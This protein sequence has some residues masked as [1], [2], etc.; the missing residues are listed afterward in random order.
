LALC[1]VGG[2]WASAGGAV[3][4]SAGGA[5]LASAAEEVFEDHGHETGSVV[6]MVV[7][8]HQWQWQVLLV[9]G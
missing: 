5:V 7:P 8:A 4:A 2:W 1:L 9:L 6:V 3:L